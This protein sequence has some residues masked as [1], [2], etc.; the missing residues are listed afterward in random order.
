M[1]PTIK[2]RPDFKEDMSELEVA[3]KAAFDVF[4][5]LHRLLLRAAGGP[6]DRVLDLLDKIAEEHRERGAEL[7]RFVSLEAENAGKAAAAAEA[8]MVR[9]ENAVANVAHLVR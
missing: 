2:I 7:P 4:R 1:H 3:T 9:L 5:H 8:A 6:E